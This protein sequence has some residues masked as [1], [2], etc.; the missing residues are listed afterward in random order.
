MGGCADTYIWILLTL[1]HTNARNT[2]TEQ[3]QTKPNEQ[4]NEQLTTSK[5]T[6][7]ENTDAEKP[8]FINKKENKNNPKKNLF[9]K[10]KTI[11]KRNATKNVQR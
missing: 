2:T 6:Q 7:K 4:P 5:Q 10:A 3:N 1:Y 8:L 9:Q 11:D